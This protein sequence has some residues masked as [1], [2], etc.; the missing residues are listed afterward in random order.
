MP[1]E[2]GS[3]TSRPPVESWKRRV[4]V[5]KS[6]CADILDFSPLRRIGAGMGG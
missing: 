2:E 5:P 6:E 3:S 1:G 4:R